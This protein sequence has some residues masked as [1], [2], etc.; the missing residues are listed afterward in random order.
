MFKYV[1]FLEE[2][3]K[4]DFLKTGGKGSNLGEMVKAGL[5]VP[6]G[7][8]ILTNAYKKFIQENNLQ[9]KIDKLI[10][11]IDPN[12]FDQLNKVSDE[13]K[14]LIYKSS[15]PDVIFKEII[16]AYDE[17]G[18]KAVAVRSSATAE[19]LPGTSFAGQYDTYLNVKG[20]EELSE[21]IIKSWSSLWNSRALSYRLK[22]NVSHK[23]LAHG[24]VVQKMI[25]GKKAGIMFSANPINGRRD[26]TLINAS[27]GLGEAVVGGEVS[28]DQWVVEKRTQKIV[29]THIADKKVMTVRTKKG[30]K[31]EEIPEKLRIKA[32]LNKKEIK[33][34]VDMSIKTEE[35]FN[36]PQD[37]EWVYENGK[38]YLVQTRPITSLF[39]MPK[40]LP[41]PRE[42]LRFYMNFNLVGQQIKEPLT[43]MGEEFWRSAMKIYTTTF[44]GKPEKKYPDW[45]KVSKGRIFMDLTI[46]FRKKKNWDK[47]LERFSDKDPIFSKA[48]L[49]WLEK[50]ESRILNE[51][52]GFRIPF[53]IFP[54]GIYIV[55]KILYGKIKPDK[56]KEKLMKV[57]KE[58]LNKISDGVKQ[59]KSIDEKLHFV[60]EKAKDLALIAFKE[61]FYVSYGIQ[62]VKFSENSLKK[63][64]GEDVDLK[65]LNKVRQSIP[66][67]P[68]TE[69]GMALLQL[70]KKYKNENREPSPNDN[71]IK[72]FLNKYGHRSS[73]EID[74]GLPR[75][76]E[77]P[78]YV[79]EL[80]NSYI[81]SGKINSK[82]DKFYKGMKEAEEALNRIVTKVQKDKGSKQA[83]KI[84][85]KLEL[86]RKTSGLRE[87][88]KYDLV[89]GISMLRDL[90]KEVGIHL[91]S[92]GRIKEANDIFYVRYKD[93]ESGEK[94]HEIVKNN[95]ERYKENLQ[96]KSVPRFITNTGETVYSITE[97]DDEGTLSGISVSPGVYEGKVRIIHDPSGAKLKSG[98]IL[99]TEGTN[100]AWTPLFLNAGALVMET[101][102]PISHGGIVAREYGIPAVAGVR[103]ATKRLKDGQK[104]RVNGESG[105]IVVLSHL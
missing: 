4:E 1:K 37:I 5:P 11:I 27:W 14:D 15:I 77:D 99:V 13:V 86:F 98:E 40:S 54:I 61:I 35:Y 89:K 33:Q 87:Q 94:L 2:I 46:L 25:N 100:P 29:D 28:P 97:E 85:S 8:V 58:E 69:M 32:A 71:E 3:T 16:K 21:A 93:I 38:F 75:W 7:F 104:I 17:I 55:S 18:N 6:G 101:G 73:I 83:K 60:E 90:L 91:V 47:I 81:S 88:P 59:L 64:F 48:L 20:F 80:I 51:G 70:S 95:K 53:R 78:S 31:T 66:N 102:G 41:D 49:E 72:D 19:D 82:I 57:S 10:K 56:A 68:T 42:E 62:S 43:P 39:P 76:K 92:E 12:D 65:D 96:I 50:N 67:N 36:F 44:T 24:V 45:F 103:E 22:N 74:I 52:K 9:E 79:I 23:D 30:T 26:Q 84:K 34:L 63:W 105:Q